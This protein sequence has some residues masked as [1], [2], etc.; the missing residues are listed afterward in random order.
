MKTAIL[1]DLRLFMCVIWTSVALF[2]LCGASQIQAQDEG[3]V[4]Y[5]S[6]EEGGGNEVKDR[7][8]NENNGQMPK[9]ETK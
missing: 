5:F 3:L 8:G 2:M 1:S 6:F 7:S 9:G 4:L